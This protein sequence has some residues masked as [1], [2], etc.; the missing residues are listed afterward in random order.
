ML[1]K[2]G[3]ACVNYSQPNYQGKIMNIEQQ[4]EDRSGS[5]CELCGS[6]PPLSV[7]GVSPSDGSAAQSI[8]I[9]NSCHQQLTGKARLDPDHWQCLKNSMWNTTPAVQVMAYRLLT[10][11]SS[12][13]WAQALLDMLYL[14][15][16]V[17]AWA[18]TR[19]ES[20]DQDSASTKDSNGTTLNAGDTVTIIK[21]L[22][23]K[24]AGFTAKRGTTVKN[25][26]LTGDPENIEGRVNRVRIVLKT[27]FLKKA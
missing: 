10:Q 12:E 11:M 5:S 23:V 8:L 15:P 27:C 3:A 9:C 4:L 19:K 22:E 24:G 6:L 21:D 26:S 1:A 7:Y 25:I 13:G 14:E 16:E 18:D 2:Q 17:Q 20:S